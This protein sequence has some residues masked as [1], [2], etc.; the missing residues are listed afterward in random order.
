MAF[1]F[2]DKF[3]KEGFERIE[4]IKIKNEPGTVMIEMNMTFLMIDYYESVL[5][6]NKFRSQRQFFVQNFVRVNKAMAE[7]YFG[8]SK[9]YSKFFKNE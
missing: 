9:E 3:T 2:L 4:K 1:E 8:N 5:K 7:G 6:N